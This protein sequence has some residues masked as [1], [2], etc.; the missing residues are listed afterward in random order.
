MRPARVLGV[1]LISAACSASGG[2]SGPVTTV[3]PMSSGV[4]P[5]NSGSMDVGAT[6]EVTAISTAVSVPPDSAFKLLRAVYAKLA[7]P[8]AQMDSAHRTVGNSGLKARRTLGGL[9]MQSVVD[10][11]E[12]IGVPNAETWDIQMDLSSYV[13]PDGAGGSQVWTR[14]QALGNDPSV[15][16]RDVTPCSTRG[17][18]EA[19]IGKAVKALVAAK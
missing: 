13:T 14:I 2:G 6:G 16:M 11:G 9:S 7:I 15:S 19:K 5:T 8:V 18:L 12:Q 3:S 10:C 4:L 17:D 1:V